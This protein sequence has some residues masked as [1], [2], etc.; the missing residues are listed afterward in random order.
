VRKR[1]TST[2]FDEFRTV[3]VSIDTG[4]RGWVAC[5]AELASAEGGGAAAAVVN[6]R[7]RRGLVCA[8]AT[9]TLQR[10]VDGGRG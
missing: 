8:S 10:A 4:G 1:V 5:G 7:W 6:C 9:P 2:E 3:E